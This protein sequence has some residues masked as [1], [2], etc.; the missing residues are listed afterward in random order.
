M[1]S[2]IV[3]KLLKTNKL[4]LGEI[5][6][7]TGRVYSFLNPVSYLEALKNK[8]LFLSL[9][10]LF[11]DGSILVF[12]INLFYLSRI[13]RRSFDMTSLAAETFN[14]AVNNNKSVYFIGS[15]QEQV[16]SAVQIFKSSYPQL[17]VVGYRNG[18]LKSEEEQIAEAKHICELNPDFLIVGLG[19]VRQEKFLLL[20]K[21][22]GFRGVGLSCGGFL[23]QTAENK[24]NYYPKWIDKLNVRFL[25]RMIVEKHTR[26]R[27]LKAAF[28]FPVK[29][30]KE[31]LSL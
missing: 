7:K 29:F 22:M 3:D 26:K 18:Y 31:R 4:S 17:N 25:Y 2:P 10:G 8:N 5:F 16:E 9:D 23:H 27:Y 30:I 20:V 21:D 11:S 6:T 15:R 13:T 28:V 14:Y 19:I 12:F 1:H 24:I